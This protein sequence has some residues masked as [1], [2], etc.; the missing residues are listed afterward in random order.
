[1]RSIEFFVKVCYTVLIQEVLPIAKH[2][3]E[4]WVYNNGRYE[5]ETVC[6]EKWMRVIYDNPKRGAPLRFLVKRKIFSRVYGYYCRTRVSARG[7]PR[8]IK[9]YN[10]DMDGCKPSYKNYTAFFTREKTGLVFPSEPH[11]FG[12]PCEGLASAYADINGTE[13]IAAKGCFFSLA[14][15]LGDAEL[16]AGY[17]G[18]SMLSIRLTPANYHRAHFFDEGKIISSKIIK[19]HLYSV[20]PLAVRRVAR[21]YCRNKRALIRFA[22]KNFGEVALVEVG[23]TFVG[24]IVHCFND[25]DAV[26]RGQLGSYFL[27]GGS[28]LLIFFKKGKFT[29]NESLLEQTAKGFESRVKIGEVIGTGKGE[30]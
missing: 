13:L 18:G 5:R 26:R 19:G 1:M 2:E 8:F 12:S 20:S 14:E 25:G 9:R 30:T 23:A 10:V 28:L 24:S 22:S 29:P 6:A 17:E 3:N 27:P 7:I 11:L 16:A 21:L 15:L 4:V